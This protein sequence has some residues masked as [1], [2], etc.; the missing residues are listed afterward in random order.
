MIILPKRYVYP[1]ADVDHNP[2]RGDTLY[3]VLKSHEEKREGTVFVVY[4]KLQKLKKTD[5]R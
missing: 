5:A 2:I 1:K 3:R 4:D